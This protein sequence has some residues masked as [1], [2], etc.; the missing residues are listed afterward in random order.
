MPSA[1][2]IER[3]MCM[4]T[5][6]D[7]KLRSAIREAEAIWEKENGEIIEQIKKEIKQREEEIRQRKAKIDDINKEIA[8]EASLPKNLRKP[9][10][11]PGSIFSMS[12]ERRVC[13]HNIKRLNSEIDRL[14]D[15]IQYRHFLL[16]AEI[17]R[18]KDRM[19]KH[20]WKNADNF[21]VD[22][23]ECTKCGLYIVTS[24]NDNDA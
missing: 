20:S 10:D 17:D 19:C 1:L 8:N 21:F 14:K 9:Y 7:E 18:L 24:P 3:R 16:G 2:K 5:I 6:K 13:E 11:W 12:D 4:E 22:A 23:I 15:R